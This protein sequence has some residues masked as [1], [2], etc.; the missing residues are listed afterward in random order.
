VLLPLLAL[1][2]GM[3]YATYVVAGIG[4]PLVA[5]A[6]LGIIAAIAVGAVLAAITNTFFWN[7]WTRAY[8]RFTA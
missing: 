5:I 3:G 7:Y 1:M 6:V 4:A 2:G 8:L